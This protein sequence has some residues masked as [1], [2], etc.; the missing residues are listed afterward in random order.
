MY[1]CMHT[2]VYVYVYMYTHTSSGGAEAV[3]EPARMCSL[4]KEC[5]RLGSGGAEGVHEPAAR[6]R[7]PQTHA[8]ALYGIVM[9]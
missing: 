8:P 6:G 9:M 3:H 4:T 2:H 5:V 1:T 7:N